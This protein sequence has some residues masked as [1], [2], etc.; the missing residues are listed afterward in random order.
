[1]LEDATKSEPSPR[2]IG[3]SS[4]A[5]LVGRRR[6]REVLERLLQS[7]AGPRGAVLVVHGEPGVGKTALL[8]FAVEAA[9]G[10]RIVRTVG[11]QSEMELPFAAVQQLCAPILELRQR[12]SRP[13]RLALEVAFGLTDGPVP[14]VFLIGL[15]ILG[16]VS[17]AAEDR[18]LLFVVDDAQWLDHASA[19]ALSIVARRLT[20]ENVALLVAARD[21]DETF[22]GLP[23]L[24]VRGLSRTDARM[25]LEAVL[26]S[27][28][29]TRVLER[30]VAETGGNP[31]ALLELPRGLSP[32]QLAGGFGLPAAVPLHAGIEDR[33]VRWFAALPADAR[34][35]VLLAAAD[36]T[37]DAALVWRAAERLGIGETAALAAES[38]GM[39]TFAGAV[40]FRHPLVRSAVYRA[41]GPEERSEV[42]R[43]IAASIDPDVDPDRRAWH[44][45][46][47]ATMPDEDIAA[48]LERSAARAQARGGFAA[49]AAF[50]ERSSALTL[51]PARRAGR[52]LA[53]A[54]ARQQAGGLDDALALVGS[55]EAG[56]LDE[57]QRA[58]AEV[59]RAR[60]LFAADRGREAPALLLAAARRLGSLDGRRAREVYLDALTAAVFAGRLGGEYDAKRVARAARAA[61]PLSP[62]PGPADL[63]L[64]GLAALITDG[65]AAGNPILRQALGAFRR[66]RIQS[67]DP[68]RWL[69]LAGRTAGFMWDY[70]SW[71]SLCTEQVRAA[72]EVGALA[73]LPLALSSCVGV[74]LFAGDLR[75]A[76]SLVEESAVLAAAVDR[77]V[78]PPYGQLSV[79]AFRGREHDF[80]SLARTSAIDFNARGEGLG[81][82]LALWVTAA[83]YNGLGR[84][85]AAFAAA[86]DATENPRELWFSTFGLVE[87]IEAASR[88]GRSQQAAEA[89]EVLI[90]STRA[91]GTPWALGV[92]ARSRAL[93]QEGDAADQLD[94]EAI[95]RL[96]PTHLKLDLARSRLVYGEWLR[97]QR[98]RLDART[99]LRAAHEL[100]ADFGMEA[101]T[102]RARIELNATGE[103]VRKRTVD[104]VEQLTPQEAQV[105]RLAAVGN[106][107]REI[108]AQ[109]FI[110]PSTV[111]YHL[112]KAFR[113]LDVSSR[114]QLARRLP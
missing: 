64:D 44:R 80:T 100:F 74:K 3:R 72:R 109:L 82:T 73:E 22:A 54:H 53:A 36:P 103:H 97:R 61:A 48:E 70:E 107:N 32:T 29:D 42:H 14:S 63:L 98:R 81:L 9:A 57:F 71:D 28:L 51:D 43:A 60:I 46:Q 77:R 26:P 108:A 94:R 41:A 27:P 40:T 12:L 114:T 10:F 62:Q 79:A 112:G 16:L 76:T 78:I 84:Y 11:V 91:S 101:F 95:E 68:L 34:R 47:G 21:P 86:T 56:P 87:L 15:A 110:S 96:E 19:A 1:M 39:L 88:S 24:T 25:L 52:A 67:E 58:Q 93:L 69:W 99:E 49:A 65:P 6:E 31:L 23:E 7:A 35:L 33:F 50:L 17:E 18:P 30:V 83:L 55:A 13:Q 85:D 38:D 37:G 105:S 8:D 59:L 4:A 104:T 102:E 92:E 5:P 20:A 106:T 111:E 66:D 2:P 45:A 113:K 75:S 90:E 89:L